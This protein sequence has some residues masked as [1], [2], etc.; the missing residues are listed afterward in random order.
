VHIYRRDESGLW[1]SSWLILEANR[2]FVGTIGRG[3][4]AT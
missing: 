3:K 2:G 1:G 4:L